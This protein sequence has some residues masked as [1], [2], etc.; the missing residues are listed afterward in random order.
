MS[1]N[2]DSKIIFTLRLASHLDFY[3]YL[4]KKMVLCLMFIKREVIW[5]VS[6]FVKKDKV[7]FRNRVE[8]EI[9]EFV[10]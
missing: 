7:L 10:C 1:S 4:I 3:T 6:C 8:S 2:D 5:G 9:Q